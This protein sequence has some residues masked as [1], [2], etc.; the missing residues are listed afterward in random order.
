MYCQAYLRHLTF[1]LDA[2]HSRD[3]CHF[4]LT[5]AKIAFC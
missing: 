4:R 3:M 5:F 1:T 2:D